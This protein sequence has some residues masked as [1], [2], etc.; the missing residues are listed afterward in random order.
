M[1]TSHSRGLYTHYL[2]D[3]SIRWYTSETFFV[4]DFLKFFLQTISKYEQ[5]NGEGRYSSLPFII[6]VLA[7]QAMVPPPKTMSSE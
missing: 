2:R 1:K 3:C 7:N 5:E 6:A 4:S